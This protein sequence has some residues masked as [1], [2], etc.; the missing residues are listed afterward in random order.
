V[1]HQRHTLL[2]QL[3]RGREHRSQARP[4][5]Q[6]G[7]DLAEGNVRGE[8]RHDA[9]DPL[10][11]ADHVAEHQRGGF[12]PLAVDPQT[13]A[14][15]EVA[16]AERRT[17]RRELSVLARDLHAVELDFA[18]FRAADHT[19]VLG[20]GHAAVTREYPENRGS[21]LERDA[22]PQR[23]LRLRP[24]GVV[25]SARVTFRGALVGHTCRS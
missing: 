25:H 15:A 5:E 13:V 2:H 11:A 8:T 18:V 4:G 7:R 14:A 16:H 17:H 6:A 9:A 24:F 23:A 20:R 12:D 19:A 1:D 10:A 22:G 3:A 21:F